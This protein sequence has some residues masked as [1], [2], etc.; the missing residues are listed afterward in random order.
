MSHESEQAGLNFNY[1]IFR[2]FLQTVENR[3]KPIDG[4]LGRQIRDD[5]APGAGFKY[6]SATMNST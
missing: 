2:R 3:P 4:G 1:A 6:A 5:T